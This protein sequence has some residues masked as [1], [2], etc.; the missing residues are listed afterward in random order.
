MK[1]SK[2]TVGMRGACLLGLGAMV[3]PWLISMSGCVTAQEMGQLQE[4][5]VELPEASGADESLDPRFGLTADA[6][7][8]SERDKE[9]GY[10]RWKAKPEPTGTAKPTDPSRRGSSWGTPP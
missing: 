2:R 10:G 9:L 1:T 6:Q 5:R 3:M 7:D 4:R 8:P